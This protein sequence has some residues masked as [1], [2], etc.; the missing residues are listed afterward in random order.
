[1]GIGNFYKKL[2]ESEARPLKK[3]KSSR[4]SIQHMNEWG[5]RFVQHV[6]KSNFFFYF[7]IGLIGFS[8]VCPGDVYEVR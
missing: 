4:L 1:M 2:D 3:N 6:L 5:G 8:R 7:F